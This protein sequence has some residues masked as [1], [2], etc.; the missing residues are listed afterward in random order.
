M[1][2]Q[3]W[4][5]QWLDWLPVALERPKSRT[6]RATVTALPVARQLG[7][8]GRVKFGIELAGTEDSAVPLATKL[9]TQS[10]SPSH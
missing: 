9:T 1:N 3:T 6:M 2:L 8:F 7:A 5:V 4:A 10:Q